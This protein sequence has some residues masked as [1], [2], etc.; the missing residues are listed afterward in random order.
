L[1]AAW[2]SPTGCSSYR[3]TVSSPS[4]TRSRSSGSGASGQ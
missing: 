2:P 3:P 4:S 1:R